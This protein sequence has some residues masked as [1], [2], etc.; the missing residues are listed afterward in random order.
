MILN[1]IHFTQNLL[2]D[3]YDVIGTVQ[4]NFLI[5]ASDKTVYQL[6][7]ETESTVKIREDP[8]GYIEKMAF[9]PVEKKIYWMNGHYIRRLN[10][11]GT[12]YET[13]YEGDLSS[14]DFD[15]VSRLVYYS[16]SHDVISVMTRDGRHHFKVIAGRPG[17]RIV[18]H[19]ARG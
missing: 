11:N 19:P 6:D 17:S 10:L 13:I 2:Y 16:A 3:I 1:I 14:F 15:R 7:M 8:N 18:L 9:D 4:D 5:V 12:G